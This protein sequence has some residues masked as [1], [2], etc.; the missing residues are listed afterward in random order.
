MNFLTS[1]GEAIILSVLLSF[2]KSFITKLLNI[3]CLEAIRS[4]FLLNTSNMVE[5][6]AQLD[7]LII[8]L[9]KTPSRKFEDS[10]EIDETSA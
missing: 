3:C 5:E 2:L 9:W 10:C 7:F 1:K 4:Y 6:N 8:N